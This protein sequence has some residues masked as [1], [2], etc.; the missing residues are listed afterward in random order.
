MKIAPQVP[1]IPGMTPLGLRPH[2]PF[3]WWRV[4]QY[5]CAECFPDSTAIRAMVDSGQGGPWYGNVEGA[6]IH[7]GVRATAYTRT[8]EATYD[9]AAWFERGTLKPAGLVT[10]TTIT[11]ERE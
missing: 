6:I 9:A 2:A 4:N 5:G 3:M 8:T 1:A 10:T 7:G 11:A